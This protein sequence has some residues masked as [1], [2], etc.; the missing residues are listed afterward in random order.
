MGLLNLTKKSPA[1]HQK[2]LLMNAGD[3]QTYMNGSGGT[4]QQ[5]YKNYIESVQAVNSAVTICASLASGAVFTFWKESGEQLK[6]MKIKNIDPYKANDYE[7][8]F[9]LERKMFGS[10]F[11]HGSALL[12]TEQSTAPMRKGLVDFLVV[13]PLQFTI[14]TGKNQTIESFTYKSG[15]GTESTL[16]YADCIYIAP[17]IDVTNQIYALPRLK[18]LNNEVVMAINSQKLGTDQLSKGNK[19]S[20]I[21]SFENPMP[22]DK[23]KELSK[24]VR[25]FME[26]QGAGLLLLDEKLKF[27]LVDR[28]GNSDEIINTLT[29]IN[30]SIYE[31]FGI[32]E[33]L[34][35]KTPS[36]GSDK[37][38]RV[39]ARLFFQTHLKPLFN[40]IEAH[41]TAYFRNTLGI[42]NAVVKFD[43]EGIG[44]LEDDKKELEE[45]LQLRWTTGIYSSNE[46]RAELGLHP[47]DNP[48]ADLH[49]MPA[50]LQGV[51]PESLENYDPASAPDTTPTVPSGPGGA[52][53]TENMGG[54]Q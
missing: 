29:F 49:F 39:I 12:V 9:D 11:T 36:S 1:A 17:S 23:Q 27:D 45:V 47:I 5:N 14:N 34:R 21:V 51:S 20:G 8:W 2:N 16:P 52:N 31:F 33:F 22:E 40:T 26:K 46:Y 32:P 3:S 42:K 54:A 30:N 38:I 6:K 44:L 7:T 15:Q 43:Y 13:N 4:A 35:G 25:Q 48:N 19:R 18:A 50:Y 28:G 41:F 53:N 37:T 10:L 24:A